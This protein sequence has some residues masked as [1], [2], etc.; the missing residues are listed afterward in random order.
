MPCLQFQDVVSC[1]RNPDVPEG[2]DEKG[3]PS[4]NQRTL[5]CAG[6]FPKSAD[7]YQMVND[8]YSPKMVRVRLQAEGR[9]S[10]WRQCSFLWWGKYQQCGNGRAVL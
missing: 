10:K 1:A 4:S 5:L 2:E 6:D 8:G 9:C 3:A 7:G